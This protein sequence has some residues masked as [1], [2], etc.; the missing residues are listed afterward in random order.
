MSRTKNRKG[1]PFS[2]SSLVKKTSEYFLL[3]FLPIYFLIPSVQAQQEASPILRTQINPQDGAEVVYLPAGEFI[4]GSDSLELRAIWNK[5]DW[6]PEELTFSQTEQPAHRVRL[7]GFW[8]YRTLVT[9]GQYSKFAQA[10]NLPFPQPPSYGWKEENPMV[11]ITWEEAGFYCA[12][13]GGRLPTEAE[14]EYGARAGNTGLNGLPRTIFVWG[15]AYPDSLVANLADQTFLDASYYDHDNFHGF[16]GYSDDFA[17]ASPAM[18]FPPNSFGLYDMAG[19][20]LEWCADW[21]SD[22]YPSDSLSVNP[23]GPASGTRKVL[24]GGA[25]DTTPTIT[26]IARR[27]GNFPDVRNEEKG[28]RCV[29]DWKTASDR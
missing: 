22:R 2:F 17:T 28:F 5:L 12:C 29:M 13:Q 10:K 19:N 11:N 25:F 21:Y 9:V 8:M 24:R 20:V 26:R 16:E 4:M 14:W 6:N 27:L 7:D 23:K 3:I 18:A 15:N 1:N